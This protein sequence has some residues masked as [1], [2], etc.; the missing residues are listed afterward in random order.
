M[1]GRDICQQNLGSFFSGNILPVLGEGSGVGRIHLLCYLRKYQ[2]SALLPITSKKR[3]CLDL[4]WH[5][6]ARWAVGSLEPSS[7]GIWRHRDSTTL[8][9]GP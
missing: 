2:L 5:V 6:C 4:G 3:I 9:A 8:A 1:E 7:Q